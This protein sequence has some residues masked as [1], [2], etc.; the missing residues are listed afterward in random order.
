MSEI[1]DD[2]QEQLGVLVV[3]DEKII[4]DE[5][6][7]FLKRERFDVYEAERPSEAYSLIEKSD[8][9]III[10][11]INLPEESGIEVLKKIKERHENIE[12]I[13]ITGKGDNDSILQS[14]RMGAFDYFQKPARLLEIKNSIERTK[15]FVK[16]SKKLERI[17]YSH[18]LISKEMEKNIGSIVGVSEAMRAVITLTLKAAKSYDTAVIINGE[19]GSGKELVARTLHYASARKDKEFI[20]VNCSAI[21]ETLIESEFFGHKKGSFTG[22]LEDRPGCFEIG[23]GGTI[24]LDEIGDMPLAAQA[25]LLRVLESRKVKRIGGSKEIP[26]DVRVVCATNKN[27]TEMIRRGEFRADLY[28]RLNA[29]EILIPPLRKRKEDIPY[30]VE[31]YVKHHALRMG[32]ETCQIDEDALGALNSYDYPG[33]IR[34][35]RNIVERAVIL[36]DKDVLTKKHFHITPMPTGEKTKNEKSPEKKVVYEDNETPLTL[37]VVDELEK[38]IL[39]RALEKCRYNKTETAKIL[40]ISRYALMRRL[41]KHDID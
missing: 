27:I 40:N 11:D 25:K 26:I 24:F 5:I 20:P 23:N 41:K 31:H 30:L 38:K 21:P 4:R 2:G 8:I 35:L 32:K 16:L 6:S 18:T 9:D 1:V 17:S 39:E 3:D 19:S 10:L 37:S 33:N 34:E 15:R 22:A 14:M 36:C 7:E 12:V 28:Y 29:V 13:M